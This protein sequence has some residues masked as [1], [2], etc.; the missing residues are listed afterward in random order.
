MSGD[1]NKGLFFRGG[2]LAFG[3]VVTCFSPYRRLIKPSRSPVPRPF[4]AKGRTTEETASKCQQ[5]CLDNFDDDILPH[6]PW[7]WNI[8]LH[9][10]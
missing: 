10:P 7:D 9:L 5:R 2:W 4:A 6:A 3:G 8:S 1:R